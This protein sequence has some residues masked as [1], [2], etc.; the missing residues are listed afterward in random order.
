MI[1]KPVMSELRYYIIQCDDIAS[2]D[3]DIFTSSGNVPDLLSYLTLC[4]FSQWGNKFCWG[5]S[6]GN[7]KNSDPHD[8]IV[9][10]ISCLKFTFF[11]IEPF[12][13]M[14]HEKRDFAVQLFEA[15]ENAV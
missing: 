6:Q 1:S 10:L 11:V 12:Q 3:H 7:E 4:S 15:S 2:H 13:T 8:M 14:N 9:I 5:G